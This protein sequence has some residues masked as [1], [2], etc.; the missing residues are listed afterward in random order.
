MWGHPPFKGIWFHVISSTSKKNLLRATESLGLLTCLL[1]IFRHIYR[2][3]EEI[4]V[5][6]LVFVFNFKLHV[7]RP[8]SRCHFGINTIIKP[9]QAEAEPLFKSNNSN[10]NGREYP[11]YAELFNFTERFPIP[12]PHSCNYE[13]AMKSFFF[14]WSIRK[15]RGWAWKPLSALTAL[16]YCHDLLRKAVESLSLKTKK[17]KKKAHLKTRLNLALTQFLGSRGK[18]ALASFF[19]HLL[20]EYLAISINYHFVRQMLNHIQIDIFQQYGS[21]HLN[22]LP[23]S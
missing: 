22:I 18:K 12:L 16:K 21:R 14:F 15:A 10:N 2:Q 20:E 17:K 7:N 11:T 1:H 9:S 4:G 8:F 13:L 19:P 3:N 23:Y 6:V 5:F